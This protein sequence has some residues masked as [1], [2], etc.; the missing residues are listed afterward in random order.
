[1]AKEHC[2][3]WELRSGQRDREIA[4]LI[5]SRSQGRKEFQPTCVRGRGGWHEEGKGGQGLVIRVK[6]KQGRCV[7]GGGWRGGGDAAMARY[8][9]HTGVGNTHWT[10]TLDHRFL[11]TYSIIYGQYPCYLWL[12]SNIAHPWLQYWVNYM[13]FNMALFLP[14]EFIDSFFYSFI[15]LRIDLFI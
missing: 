15:F 6:K 13:Q 2:T 4:D 5:D 1:M 9:T 11:N 7:G 12:G 14:L 8:G 10:Q 3:C